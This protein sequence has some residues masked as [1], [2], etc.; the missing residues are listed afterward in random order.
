LKDVSDAELYGI[1]EEVMDVFIAKKFEPS[2]IVPMLRRHG[3]KN[4]NDISNG[5]EEMI[6]EKLEEEYKNE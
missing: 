5:V 6:E 1:S 3:I 4:I 2:D